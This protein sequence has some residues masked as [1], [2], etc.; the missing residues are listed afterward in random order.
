M[1]HE[2]KEQCYFDGYMQNNLNIQSQML[3]NY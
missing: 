3:L 2:K 1:I